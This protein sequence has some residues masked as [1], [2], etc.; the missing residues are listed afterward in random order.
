MDSQ[1]MWQRT[2]LTDGDKRYDITFKIS[3]YEKGNL[4]LSLF[5]STGI[6]SP[7]YK[8]KDVFFPVK[9]TRVYEGSYTEH[10]TET[11]DFLIFNL[12]KWLIP[13]NT[14]YLWS[15]EGKLTMDALKF[16]TQ[17]D[18]E[19]YIVTYGKSK[20]IGYVYNKKLFELNER[21]RHDEKPE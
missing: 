11:Y 18:D 17:K 5:I 12:G 16:S 20:K 15:E 21:P 9:R 6:P 10:C 2:S 13:D 14:L 7:D 8:R 1:R 19:F 3:R 4:T